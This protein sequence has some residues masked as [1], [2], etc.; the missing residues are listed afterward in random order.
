MSTARMSELP[1]EAGLILSHAGGARNAGCA[2][3]AKS[4]A[5]GLAGRARLARGGMKATVPG[6]GGPVGETRQ[7]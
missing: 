3:L 1:C 7:P 6:H 4:E 2:A 5:T